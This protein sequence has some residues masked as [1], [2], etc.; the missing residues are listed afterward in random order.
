LK[1]NLD[2]ES[3]LLISLN[4][5]SRLNVAFMLNACEHSI[6][7]N[8]YSL[9]NRGIACRPKFHFPT[10]QLVEKKKHKNMY[11]KALGPESTKDESKEELASR[12]FFRG[13]VDVSSSRITESMDSLRLL[14]DD[15][16]RRLF[17]TSFN[18]NHKHKICSLYI[19]LMNK[20]Y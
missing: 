16:S 19:I 2:I 6:Q 11:F 3:S 5:Y 4:N 9:L 8:L 10:C 1:L 15:R 17:S 20:E 7:H 14:C 13:S 12:R 18:L